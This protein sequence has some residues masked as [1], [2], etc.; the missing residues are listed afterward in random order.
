M[1]CALHKSLVKP[2]EP[3]SRAAALF[4]PN[5]LKPAASR[6]STMPAT[7][8]ASGPTTTKSTLFALQNATT[9]AWSAMSTATH[10]AS[11][12]IPALPGAHQSLVVSGEAAIF[13]ASAC[14]RPPEPSRRMFMGR[15]CSRI[16]PERSCP[17]LAA[18][19]PDPVDQALHVADGEDL[20]AHHVTG[21][22]V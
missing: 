22:V 2:L 19:L 14:S 15:G 11:R 3:S 17:H 5:V 16:R 7:S 12:A 6:S 4:G 20:A 8:G 1:L 10:S 13:Q 9:A 21:C 18:F